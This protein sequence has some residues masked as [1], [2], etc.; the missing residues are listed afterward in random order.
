MTNL[1]ELP[2]EQAYEIACRAVNFKPWFEFKGR[3]ECIK[4]AQAKPLPGAAEIAFTRGAIK[5][6]GKIVNRVV[7]SHF[8]VLQAIN[9]PLL[10][11]IES[12]ARD[13]SAKVDF[14]PE[15]Q[16]EIC[17]IFTEDSKS[18][19]RALKDKG[20]DFVRDQALNVVGEGWDAAAVNLVMIAV[21]EQMKR[22]V[23]TTIK[24]A[25]EMEA[26]GDVSFFRE[27]NHEASKRLE[28]AGS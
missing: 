25:A 27:L 19:Y 15:S 21:I 16:W 8:A 17:Y 23:E 14:S 3:Q 18:V 7:P 13:K 24:F 11:M 9:S 26:S 2:Q 20:A 4:K 12:A 22:H 10:S 6:G 1:H 5:A 28:S